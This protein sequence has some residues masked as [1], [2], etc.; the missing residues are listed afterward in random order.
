MNGMNFFNLH[1]R[2]AWDFCNS[3]FENSQEWN[4]LNQGENSTRLYKVKDDFKVKATLVVPFGKVGALALN[5]SMNHQLNAANEV[6]ALCSK[7]SDTAIN[8][9][10]LLAASKG[11]FQVSMCFTII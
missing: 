2:I 11:I 7:L 9:P 10:S 3:F 4:L 8:C 5:Q 1:E 6:C